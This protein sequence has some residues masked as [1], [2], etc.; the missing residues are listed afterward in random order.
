MRSLLFQEGYRCNFFQAV[1]L[2]ERLAPSRE[3][4]GAGGPP[5]GEVVRFRTRA[6]LQFPASEI[7]EIKDSE[8]PGAPPEMT[9]SF[10]GMTGPLGLLPHPYTELVI[11]RNKAKDRA[12]GEFLDL[13]NHRILSFF[14]RAWLKYRFAAGYERAQADPLTEYLFDL[15]GMGTGGLR[16][17]L[18]VP[19]KGLL[20]YAG[21]IAQKPHSAT[22][23]EGILRDYFGIPVRVVQ[24]CGQW[25]ALDPEHRSRI[26]A[27][28][29]DL[30]TNMVCGER[31]RVFQSKFRLRLGPLT[32]RQFRGFLPSGGSFR[33]VADLARFLA[34]LEFDYDIQLILKKEEVPGCS[35]A[36]EAEPP[37]MLGWT[38]WLKTEDLTEDASEV[39]LAAP[40]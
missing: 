17:R 5:S 27:A 13:F 28:N 36:T 38:T 16:G 14:Y 19:D 24:F 34:G 35:L 37:P 2:L 33:P 6:S 40:N 8:R 31:V 22:A 11:E 9:V 1:R 18:A 30:G 7:H 29:S 4:V 12:L 23:T 3:P 20:L 26:G 32:F 25:V 21:A 39:V 15:I 10:F